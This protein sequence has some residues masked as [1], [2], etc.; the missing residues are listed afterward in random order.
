MAAPQLMTQQDTNLQYD[1]AQDQMLCTLQP[2]E[3]GQ[4]S[5]LH[6]PVFQASVPIRPGP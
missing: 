2:G 1:S 6:L 5:P 4:C 3:E